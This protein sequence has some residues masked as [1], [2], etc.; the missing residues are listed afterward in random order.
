MIAALGAGEEG[1]L[2]PTKLIQAPLCEESE[3]GSTVTTTGPHRYMYLVDF[4]Q[5]VLQYL[6]EYDP[7][8]VGD[9]IIPSPAPLLRSPVF[10]SVNRV[11]PG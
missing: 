9:A 8:T 11:L 3:D 5:E 4:S 6:Q 10:G 2:G 7:I 1:L